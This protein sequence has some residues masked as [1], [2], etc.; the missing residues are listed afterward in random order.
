MQFDQAIRH[1]ERELLM[2]REELV[3]GKTQRWDILLS[4]LVRSW[5]HPIENIILIEMQRPLATR[6]E[7]AAAWHHVVRCVIGV[8]SPVFIIDAPTGCRRRFAFGEHWLSHNA[9]QSPMEQVF[10][11]LQTVG[12]SRP[13]SRYVPGS[14]RQ[15]IRWAER[16]AARQGIKVLYDRAPNGEGYSLGGTI[17]ADCR[18]HDLDR[19]RQLLSLLAEEMVRRPCQ[20]PAAGARIPPDAG[21]AP[22]AV[23]GV[24]ITD[25]AALDGVAAEYVAYVAVSVALPGPARPPP[26][27]PEL[28]DTGV[29]TLT[30]FLAR[31]QQASANILEGLQ[32]ELAEELPV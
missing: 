28:T 23:E 27:P 5:N 32:A 29:L 1:V 13:R 7:T 10:D 31:V 2:L 25:S 18:G 4:S 30:R 17:I 21:H 9:G 26:P 3:I 20:H 12:A 11:V 8:A 14:I 24:A 19:A 16:F 22:G 15:T 6:V